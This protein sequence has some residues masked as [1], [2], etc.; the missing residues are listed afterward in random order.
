MT[1]S[2]PNRRYANALR[3]LGLGED[4]TAFF[5]EHVVADAVHEN[6]AAVDLA[7]GLVRQQP[8]LCADVL[9]GARALVALDARWAAHLLE[10]WEAGRSSLR[11]PLQAVAP[12]A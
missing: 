10:A 1:S 4:A 12:V 8:D 6:I 3:R 9:W 11:A 5:D 2:V 7:G